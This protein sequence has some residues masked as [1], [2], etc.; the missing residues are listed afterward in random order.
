MVACYPHV[1]RLATGSAK[2]ITMETYAR[3]LATAEQSTAAADMHHPAAASAAAKRGSTAWQAVLDGGEQ[4]TAVASPRYSTSAAAAAAGG[5]GGGDGG[6]GS[7]SGGEDDPTAAADGPGPAV[8]NEVLKQ[9]RWRATVARL[10]LSCDTAS[11][12][13]LAA[14]IVLRLLWSRHLVF[15]LQS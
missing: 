1:K 11:S 6:G 5:G 14:Y 9:V 10:Q 4:T 12:C 3:L 15:T 2:S 7:S 13:V 8:I